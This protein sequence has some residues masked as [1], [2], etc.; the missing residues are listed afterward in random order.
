MKT[1]PEQL[2][3][4][5][6]GFVMSQTTQVPAAV[7][8]LTCRMTLSGWLKLGELVRAFPLL[9]GV[10]G[11]RPSNFLPHVSTLH[12]HTHTQ[13]YNKDDDDDEEVR[14]LSLPLFLNLFPLW[15]LR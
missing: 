3:K 9:P 7:A 6:Y 12:V 1:S 10:E 14:P 2:M 4:R 11:H 8:A 15:T 13:L 5:L